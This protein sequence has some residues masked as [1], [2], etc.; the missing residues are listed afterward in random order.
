MAETRKL[1]KDFHKRYV[2]GAKKAFERA[3][4]GANMRKLYKEI[5]KMKKETVAHHMSK[6]VYTID[7]NSKIMDA[8]SILRQHNFGALVVTENDVPEGVLT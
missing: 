4:Y 2:I 7:V 8:L 5:S 3:K 1:L 6:K